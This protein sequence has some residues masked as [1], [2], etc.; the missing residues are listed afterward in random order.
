MTQLIRRFTVAGIAA[1]VAL[2][3]LADNH[4]ADPASIT[5]ADFMAMDAEGQAAAV[6]AMQAAS[7]D[8]EMM[9]D[10]MSE[11]DD[12]MMSDDEMSGE[13]DAMMSEEGMA[14]DDGDMMSEDMVAGMASACDGSPDMMAIDAMAGDM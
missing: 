2:P 5:C 10:E 7:M 12:G 3:A 4:A 13:D 14:S 6:E 8:G 11:G 9:T 1:L